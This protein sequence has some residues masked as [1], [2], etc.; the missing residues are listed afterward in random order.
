VT[1]V[2]L[3]ETAAITGALAVVSGVFLLAG[4]TR[5]FIPRASCP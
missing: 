3:A 1:A 2:H 4:G 5:L